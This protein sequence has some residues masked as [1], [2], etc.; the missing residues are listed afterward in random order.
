MKS[1]GRERHYVYY[2]G[3]EWGRKLTAVK[4]SWQ[5]PVFLLVNVGWRKE[6]RLEVKKMLWNML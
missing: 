4:V 6:E 1:I 2:K 5:G 3:W